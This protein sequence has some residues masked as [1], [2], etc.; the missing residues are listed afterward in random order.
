MTRYERGF[1]SR[2]RKIEKANEELERYQQDYKDKNRK[3]QDGETVRMS[4]KYGKFSFL[5]LIW[6]DR[7]DCTG[8]FYYYAHK[9]KE[10][11][12]PEYFRVSDPWAY[13][14]EKI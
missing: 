13:N 7:V 11:G 5:A 3:Y 10:D 8:K 9:L 4:H 2:C 14:F 1:L 6:L 12:E